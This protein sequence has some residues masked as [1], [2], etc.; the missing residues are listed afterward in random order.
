MSQYI[1]AYFVGCLTSTFGVFIQR[2]SSNKPLLYESLLKGRLFFF[3]SCRETDV[4]ERSAALRKEAPRNLH[5]VLS[6]MKLGSHEALNCENDGMD[7]GPQNGEPKKYSRNMIGTCLPI[8][9]LPS[10]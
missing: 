1:W 7:E 9:F 5:R 6:A 2:A 3:G 8:V 10:S 4:Q